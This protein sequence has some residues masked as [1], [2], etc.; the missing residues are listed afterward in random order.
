MPDEFTLAEARRTDF[1]RINIGSGSLLGAGSEKNFTGT[2]EK[3][4]SLGTNQANK[5]RTK[6]NENN[7]NQ[8]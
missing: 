2:I 1:D 4:Q 5:G 3:V 7:T 6:S 8:G